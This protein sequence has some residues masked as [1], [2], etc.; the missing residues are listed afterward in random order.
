MESVFELDEA[1]PTILKIGG[2]VITDKNGELAAR[3]EVINR[4]AEEIAK[5]N[6][7]NLII[8]H[9]GGSFG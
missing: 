5:A 6:T 1:K 9:G 2:S 4:L 8:V 7:K 3:T